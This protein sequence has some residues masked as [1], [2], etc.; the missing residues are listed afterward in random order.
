MGGRE[1][2]ARRLFDAFRDEL[3]EQRHWDSDFTPAPHE[4]G[5]KLRELVDAAGVAAVPLLLEALHG[6]SDLR[7]W[8]LIGLQW[9]GPPAGEAAV[10]ALVEHIEA[11]R[12]P[13]WPAVVALDAVAPERVRALGVHLLPTAMEHLTDRYLRL[14]GD[15]IVE[16]VERFVR[17]ESDEDVVRFLGQRRLRDRLVHD[18]PPRLVHLLRDTMRGGRDAP[19]R[20]AAAEI[21]A[22][23][24]PVTED[25]VEALRHGGPLWRGIVERVAAHP[26]S[27]RLVPRL[28]QQ[29]GATDALA[30]LVVRRRAAGLTTDPGPL[31]EFLRL[32]VDEPRGRWPG[33]RFGASVPEAI[34]ALG[35]E[36]LLVHLLPMLHEDRLSGSERSAVM[37][38]FASFGERGTAMLQREH[39]AKVQRV[40]RRI[41]DADDAFL[42][43]RIETTLGGAFDA[44]AGILLAGP[45]AHAAF[46]LAWIDRAYG[47]PVTAARVAWIRGLGFT[48]ER[49]L[50]EVARPVDRPLEGLRV[51]WDRGEAGRHD[52]A[53]AARAA[54]AGLPSLAYG[55]LR[56][57]A[58]ADAARA[59][60]DEVRAAAGL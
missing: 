54:A 15:A 8:A 49:L 7:F 55:W 11:G 26:A 20:R 33:P 1:A 3:W 18:C 32:C 35:D 47:A 12:E 42:R 43:G 28:V 30:A 25:L 38:A 29:P 34:G 2:E 6:D 40:V 5:A 51:E 53:R 36:T 50:A 16:H 22:M 17:E 57:E 31:R 48:G 60:L 9:V 56:H 41:E 52:P 27:E 10:A 4:P 59:H 46:Q 58:Y 44:Y 23:L 24:D 19:V 13:L 14:S 37:A 21:L 39:G 45:S